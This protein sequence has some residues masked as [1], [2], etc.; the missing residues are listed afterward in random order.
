MDRGE[1]VR[2]SGASDRDQ[3]RNRCRDLG[4]LGALRAQGEVRGPWGCPAVHAE[5]R[6]LTI[7]VMAALECCAAEKIMSRASEGVGSRARVTA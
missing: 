6:L 3:G 2:G 7:S 5:G 4:A 1:R